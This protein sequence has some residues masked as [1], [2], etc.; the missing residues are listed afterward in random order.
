MFLDSP[1][2][3]GSLGSPRSPTVSP[4]AKR[5]RGR[6][7]KPDAADV[8]LTFRMLDK[9]LKED[10]MDK[11]E[12]KK[13]KGGKVKKVLR[14]T[15]RKPR[16]AGPKHRSMARYLVKM[17]KIIAVRG[18]EAPKISVKTMHVLE[19]ML[20]ELYG[21]ISEEAIKLAKQKKNPSFGISEIHTAVRLIVPPELAD[22]TIKNNWDSLKHYHDSLT[23]IKKMKEKAKARSR[24]RSPSE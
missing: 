16:H 12:K 18:K 7:R 23:R 11:M 24:S 10:K 5:G 6:P 2:S 21:K 14:E 1:R 9:G 8:G 13:T 4:P 3:V 19:D 20:R 15:K 17:N 22:E